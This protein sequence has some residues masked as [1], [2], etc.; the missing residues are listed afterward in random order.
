MYIVYCVIVQFPIQYSREKE[1]MDLGDF[2]LEGTE[3]EMGNDRIG[4]GRKMKL[5]KVKSSENH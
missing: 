5:E 2:G 3:Q 4:N 1:E